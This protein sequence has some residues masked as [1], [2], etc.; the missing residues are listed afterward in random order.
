MMILTVKLQNASMQ[1]F[2][3]G[4]SGGEE[5]V[6]TC[7]SIQQKSKQTLM[8]SW[9]GSKLAWTKQMTKLQYKT[10]EEKP[11]SLNEV[12]DARVTCP[13]LL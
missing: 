3:R 5:E 12:V 2:S 7:L 13:S 4:G 8:E 10:I 1:L 11:S 6:S 9:D